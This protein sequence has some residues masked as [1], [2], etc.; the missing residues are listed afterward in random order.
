MM[1]TCKIKEGNTFSGNLLS[2]E[3][4]TDKKGRGFS[5]DRAAEEIR[6]RSEEPES[7]DALRGTDWIQVKSELRFTAAE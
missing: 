2:K 4:E 5:R 1:E 7:A 3:C 6:K